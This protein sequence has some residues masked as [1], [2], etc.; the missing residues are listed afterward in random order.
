MREKKEDSLPVKT[1]CLM[2][3]IMIKCKQIAELLSSFL[4][5]GTGGFSLL[6][7]PTL[8]LDVSVDDWRGAVP[9]GERVTAGFGR[10]HV[11]KQDRDT[12]YKVL[13]EISAQL[14]LN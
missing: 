14:L 4:M 5:D 12:V 11:G 6:A 13:C 10:V 3:N 9:C 2:I 7:P 1:S 8:R